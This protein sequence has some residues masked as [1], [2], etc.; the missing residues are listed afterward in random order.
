MKGSDMPGYR[1]ALAIPLLTP[2]GLSDWI[3]S[4]TVTPERTCCE[5]RQCSPRLSFS[6]TPSRSMY[7]VI[8]PLSQAQT[9][10]GW[11]Q[12]LKKHIAHISH[13]FVFK[14]FGN[15][16][17]ICIAEILHQYIGWYIT[18][19]YA[20]THIHSHIRTHSHSHTASV[21]AGCWALG[22]LTRDS[23]SCPL[24]AALSPKEKLG[25]NCMREKVCC[26]FL[27]LIHKDQH[28]HIHTHTK[29]THNRSI[30][31]LALPWL[32]YALIH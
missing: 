3:V 1:V 4:R 18:C 27:S 8:L 11:S 7:Y 12:S 15:E 30:F 10:D 6:L 9:S 21:V 29:H 25:Q 5:W 13:P 32:F 16:A 31:I 17:V 23:Y 14:L 26:I 28:T 22:V 20:H 2:G 24:V 19:M